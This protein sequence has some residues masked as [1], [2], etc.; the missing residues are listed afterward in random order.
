MEANKHLFRCPGF[1]DLLNGQEYEIFF[2]PDES[3]ENL[4]IAAEKMREA[5]GR[6]KSIQGME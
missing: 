5:N 6:L 3:L 4:K 2:K 1:K